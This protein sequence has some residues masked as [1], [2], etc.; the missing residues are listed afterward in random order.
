MPPTI[1][2]FLT[3][4]NLAPC[5]LAP[6]AYKMLAATLC[7]FKDVGGDLD[8]RSLAALFYLVKNKNSS[9]LTLR[10]RAAPPI[11]TDLPSSEKGWNS[12]P[13]VITEDVWGAS[14][15]TSLPP[16]IPCQTTD[17]PNVGKLN[18]LSAKNAGLLNELL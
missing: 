9:K 1:A 11:V 7:M 2:E 3:L 12:K 5:Q 18:H 6:N 10:S 4:V 17:L 14:A 8:G 13:L 16:A 15:D